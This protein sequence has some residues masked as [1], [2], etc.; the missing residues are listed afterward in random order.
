[1]S[2]QAASEG[3]IEQTATREDLERLA[4]RLSLEGLDGDPA[5]LA[6][7][8]EVE[9]QLKELS[10]VEQRAERAAREAER[11]AAEQQREQEAARRQQLRTELAEHGERQVAVA[12]ELEK[13]LAGVTRLR[14]QLDALN[15]EASAVC[16]G[17]GVSVPDGKRRIATVCMSKALGLPIDVALKGLADQ[18]GNR[19]LHEI[20]AGLFSKAIAMSEA[21]EHPPAPAPRPQ[22][23]GTVDVIKNGATART[24]GQR[25]EDRVGRLVASGDDVV[26]VD[27]AGH[28]RFRARTAEGARRIAEDRGWSIEKEA[29]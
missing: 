21:V 15:V 4:E 6:Q 17:L 7:L 14:Q 10:R 16:A 24:K 11:R 20:L 25:T 1:M 29:S 23:N 12:K 22:A 13:S 26:V 19:P 9:A 28:I 27:A 5:V 2:A 8:A 3:A 18:L